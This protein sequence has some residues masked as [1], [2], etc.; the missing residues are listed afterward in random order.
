M[1]VTEVK[2]GL[3]VKVALPGSWCGVRQIST[4]VWFRCEIIEVNS[5]KAITLGNLWNK[6]YNMRIDRLMCFSKDGEYKRL[7]KQK[8]GNGRKNN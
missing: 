3:K 5:D 8:S 1:K 7:K 2:T 6:K 4:Y